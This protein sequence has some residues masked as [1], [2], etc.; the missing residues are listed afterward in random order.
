MQNFLE[1][2]QKIKEISCGNCEFCGKLEHN[3]EIY[4]QTPTLRHILQNVTC[5][6][7]KKITPLGVIFNEHAVSR[8]LWEKTPPVIYLDRFSQSGSSNHTRESA[9]SL[10]FPYL[11]LHRMGLA[12]QRH[13]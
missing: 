10:N 9:G 3:N 8:V 12:R 5:K 13:Y 2:P 7:H 6:K 4:N 1:N 11:I